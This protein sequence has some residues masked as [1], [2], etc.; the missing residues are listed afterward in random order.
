MISCIASSVTG[1][2]NP[3]DGGWLNES[4]SQGGAL[5]HPSSS[6]FSINGQIGAVGITEIF[7][8]S[9]FADGPSAFR[10]QGNI[11]GWF[12]GV[13]DFKFIN[14]ISTLSPRLIFSPFN[15]Q[16]Y[17]LSFNGVKGFFNARSLDG[18][19]LPWHGH[20]GILLL[21]SLENT[22]LQFLDPGFQLLGF[23][24]Q[25]F[26]CFLA[27]F[28]FFGGTHFPGTVANPPKSGI[29]S[30]V[31]LLGNGIK[32]VVVASAAS[33]RQAQEGLGGG[34]D[35]F[36]DGVG[37]YLGCLRRILVANIII[38]A[39]YQEGCADGNTWVVG[40]ELIPC[41]MLQNQLI[42][43]LVC[44]EGVDDVVPKWPG[45]EDDFI[46]LESTTFTKANHIQPVA[47][48]AFSVGRGVQ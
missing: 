45:I 14:A 11:P 35:D 16:S 34:P 25:W 4:Q 37:S 40:C 3:I 18:A 9:A 10:E 5:S 39:A 2:K 1:E 13:P 32:L 19:T 44:V 33:H 12:F 7:G 29:P 6:P 26:Q 28:F 36:I 8:D 42:Q 17:V 20:G 23:L 24:L 38:R 22:F 15:D 31:I 46:A 41:Q 47:S 27:K 21:G 30:V 43:G 48:P